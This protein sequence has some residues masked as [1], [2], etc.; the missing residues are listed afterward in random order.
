MLDDPTSPIFRLIAEQLPHLKAWRAEYR[1][2]LPAEPALRPGWD[3]QHGPVPYSTLGHAIDARLRLSLT[4]VAVAAAF[5]TGV[6][7]YTTDALIYDGIMGPGM[8]EQTRQLLVHDLI[9]GLPPTTP[10]LSRGRRHV[11]AAAVRVLTDAAAL[12]REAEPWRGAGLVLDDAAEDQLCRAAFVLGWLEECFRAGRIFPGSVLEGLIVASTDTNDVDATGRRLLALVPQ[13]VVEDLKATLRLAERVGTWAQLRQSQTLAL[14]PTFAG[15]RLV[16]GADAD[17][18]ADG[19]LIDVKATV[20]P[21]RAKP[22][23]LRQLLGYTLLDFDDKY[24]I[25]SVGLFLARHGVLIS[26]PLDQ[27]LQL[28][29]SSRAALT[30]LRVQLRAELEARRL[31]SLSD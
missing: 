10:Q 8:S 27:L 21:R 18:I 6:C 2:R 26:W 28:L 20:D 19:L 23:D 1:Q 13:P 25:D 9:R 17:V 16:G 3:N 31:A 12:A 14:G 4:E 30:D 22:Q 15:S 24:G 29:G 11:G 5:E 7:R